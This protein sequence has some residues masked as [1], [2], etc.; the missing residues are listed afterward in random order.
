MIDLQAA[1]CRENWVDIELVPRRLDFAHAVIRPRGG[2]DIKAREVTRQLSKRP[3]DHDYSNDVSKSL[4][5]QTEMTIGKTAA[6]NPCPT[7]Q[8]RNSCVSIGQV[9]GRT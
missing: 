2:I 9:S 4:L 3:F 5:Q 7:R 6:R 8:H 1:G